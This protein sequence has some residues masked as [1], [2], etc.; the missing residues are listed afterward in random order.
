MR[1]IC[2]DNRDHLLGKDESWKIGSDIANEN[3][4]DQGLMRSGTITNMLNIGK[5]RTEIEARNRLRL[6][7]RLPPISVGAELRKLY[8]SHRQNEFDH[9]FQTSP[10]RKRVE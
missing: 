9:F 2:S 4:P 7:T 8:Q 10:L 5:A 1:K 3:R 6:E